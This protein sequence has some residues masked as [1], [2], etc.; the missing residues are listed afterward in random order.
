MKQIAVDH[1]SVDKGLKLA[2][3]SAKCYNETILTGN[4]PLLILS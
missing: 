4:Y 2:Y 1:S 3:V